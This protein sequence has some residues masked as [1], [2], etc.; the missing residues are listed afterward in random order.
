MAEFIVEDSSRKIQRDVYEQLGKDIVRFLVELI[1]NSDDSY[2]RLEKSTFATDEYVSS[3]K[4]IKII[5]ND[6]DGDGKDYFEVIDYAEGMD[7]ARMKAV[8]ERYGGD[9]AGGDQY[10]TRGIFGQG[11]SDVLKASAY[12]KKKA[13]IKSIK[14]NKLYQMKYRFDNNDNKFK[15]EPIL[16]NMNVNQFK[17]FRNKYGIENNGTIFI[18]GVP[19]TVKVNKKK[20]LNEIQRNAMLRYILNDK[21]REVTLQI[22]SKKNSLAETILSSS[23]FAFSDD[24]KLGEENFNFLYEGINL[25]INVCFYKNLDKNNNE[26][27]I[28]V[29]DKNN[30]VFANTMFG[31]DLNQGVANISGE[32]VI[33]GLYELCKKKLND[34]INAEAIISPNRTGF[35]EKK[36]FYLKLR[37][38]MKPI[39]DQVIKNYGDKNQGLDIT[40][41]KKWNDALKKLNMYAKDFIQEEVGGG[42]D[43]GIELPSNGIVFARNNVSLSVGKKYDLKLY[44]NSSIIRPGDT[45]K[46]SIDNNSFVN[47][48]TDEVSYNND[49]E[50]RENGL[51]VKSVVLE[52]LTDSGDEMVQL[53]ASFEDRNAFSFIKVITKEIH[54]PQNGLEFYPSRIKSVYTEIHAGNLYVDTTIFPIGSTIA[55]NANGLALKKSEFVVQETDIIDNGIA[56]LF[57]ESTGGEIDKK[58]T[59]SALC[60]EVPSNL[61]INIIEKKNDDMGSSGLISGFNITSRK[62]ML[63]QRCYLDPTNG[64]IFINSA[65][66]I[67]RLTLEK[68]DNKD[69]GNPK[70]SVTE[71]KF[72]CDMI[73]GVAAEAIMKK[74]T[75]F[76]ASLSSDNPLDAYDQAAVEIGDRKNDCF[77]LLYKVLMNVAEEE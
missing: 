57:I 25:P 61:I 15:G 73:A 39:I 2:R 23:Q 54:Y 21:R 35:D 41:N 6:N 26:T 29:R 58:Y 20:L 8:F 7:E 69:V 30:V 75:G 59:V 5:Y 68:I 24:L 19:E 74:E 14:N 37:K 12:S 56:R 28:I 32:M 47:L 49:D 63:Y 42:N 38:E 13:L 17:D 64:I 51:V 16:I 43:T 72:L 9:N 67:N 77:E 33:D 3:V 36:D 34:H 65:N 48:I 18:F 55:I 4:K 71:T 27:Q 46:L 11:A 45:I 66:V 22:D 10:Q 50:V 52:A 62:D 44:I 70:F 76:I 40:K 53:K 1:T 31:Y 60:N